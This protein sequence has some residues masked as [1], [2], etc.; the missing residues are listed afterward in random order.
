MAQAVRSALA[1]FEQR[2]T[3]LPLWLKLAYALFVCVLV[4]AYSVEH[5][6]R[7]FLWFS[8]VALLATM[9]AVWLE[10]RLLTSMMA[11]AVV[12]PEVGWNLDF[13]A[14][15]FLGESFLG[16]TDYMFDDDY[17]LLVR[18]LSLYHVVLPLLLLWL[19]SRLGYDR[20]AIGAQTLLAWVILPLSYA[21]TDP[22]R[23][24]NWVYGPGGKGQDYMPEL[25]WLGLL[26][27]GFPLLFYLPSHFLFAWLLGDKGK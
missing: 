14:G 19:L 22:D 27:I 6:L 10:S 20:R 11:L 15:L 3:R 16:L 26:M 7:N 4:P 21:V 18:G 1:A 23:N 2:P 13:F 24:V 17:S 12:L 8:N 25:A 5:G 9:L